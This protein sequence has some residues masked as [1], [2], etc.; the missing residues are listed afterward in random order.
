MVSWPFAFVIRELTSS[1][2][3]AIEVSVK[4]D[5]VF[6]SNRAACTFP[7]TFLS[8]ASPDR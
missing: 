3:K 2:T 7:P 1:Y 8:E 4:R 5:A 6:Y